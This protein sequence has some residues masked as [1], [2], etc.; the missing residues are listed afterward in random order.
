MFAAANLVI[1]LESRSPSILI[2]RFAGRGGRGS[3]LVEHRGNGSAT[4]PRSA[5]GKAIA[6]ALAGTPAALAL[7]LPAG[8]VL[9][10][11]TSWHVTFAVMAALAWR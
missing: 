10:D 6:V 5:Q 8:T 9:G 11:A 3:D 4:G 1:A 2:A 7:G